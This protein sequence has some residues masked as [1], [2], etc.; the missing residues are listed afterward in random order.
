[1]NDE[2][3]ALREALDAAIHRTKPRGRIVALT[4]HSLDG[5]E[6]KGAFRRASK[7]SPCPPFPS[8]EAPQVKILTKKVVKP[9]REEIEA[10]PRARSAHLR[11]AERL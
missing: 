8:E 6:T 1:M 5:G 3:G 7:R 10:N 2:L 9:S 4:Y 11:A